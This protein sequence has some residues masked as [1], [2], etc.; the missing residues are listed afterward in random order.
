MKGSDLVPS[1]LLSYTLTQPSPDPAA[2]WYG[3]SGFSAI[4]VT[5]CDDRISTSSV[6]FGF[7]HRTF[8]LEREFG[9]AA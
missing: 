1:I 8:V 9:I 2:R 4:E 6:Q 7:E 3:T 5:G